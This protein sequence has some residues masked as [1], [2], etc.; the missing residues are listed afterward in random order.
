MAKAKI[1]DNTQAILKESDRLIKEKLTLSAL[2]V[3]RTAK[4]ECPVKT[5]TARRSIT[6]KVG[7]RRAVVGSNVSYFKWIEMGTRKMSAFAPLR[8]S[9]ETNMRKIR[10]IFGAK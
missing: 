1:K 3:E 6:H 7:K 8:R 9:L 5:G 2:L 4:Q 10:Q